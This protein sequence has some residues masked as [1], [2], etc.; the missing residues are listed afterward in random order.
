M[1]MCEGDRVKQVMALW[2]RL[3]LVIILLLIGL[4]TSITPEGLQVQQG[5]V[6]DTRQTA[7]GARPRIQ[8]LVL[9][10][11]AE[12]FPASLR[13]LT[14][15]AVSTHYLLP[16]TPPKYAGK[17]QV[18]QLVDEHMLAWHA[19]VSY[20]RGATRLNDTSIGIELENAGWHRDGKNIIWEPYSASQ[21]AALLPLARDI[22]QRYHIPP[23]NVVAH[24]DIAP[25]RKQDPGPLFPWKWLAEQGVGAWPDADRVAF[26][27][28]GRQPSQQ[29]D[30]K[31]LLH[32]LAQ[33]GYQVTAKMTPYQQQVLIATFQMHFRAQDCRGYADAES[34]AIAEALVEKYVTSAT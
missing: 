4:F 26:Y 7:Y 24:S 25:M 27:L 1:Q 21:M 8:A 20:W 30:K 14:G 32:L 23:Q 3:R 31:K 13:T 34:E 2:R 16:A 33:Y 11:T 28:A 29:V 12:N 18:W 5:Y 10:Y 17:P 15:H 19:G 6:L 22:I 9:H